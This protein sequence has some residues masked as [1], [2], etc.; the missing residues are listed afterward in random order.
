MLIKEVLIK[1]C[2]KVLI[3]VFIYNPIQSTLAGQMITFTTKTTSKLCTTDPL[4]DGLVPLLK[5]RI[6]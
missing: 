4:C 6:S 5:T 2:P 3:K 1:Y